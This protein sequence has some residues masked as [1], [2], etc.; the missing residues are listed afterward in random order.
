ME[1]APD[2]RGLLIIPFMTVIG[3]LAA[4]IP[5]WLIQK[6]DVVRSLE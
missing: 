4:M 3:T 5:A 1:T 6:K 2:P